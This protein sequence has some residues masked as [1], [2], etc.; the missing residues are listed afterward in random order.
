DAEVWGIDI[1]APMVRY[2]HMRARRLGVEVQFAQRLAEKT[3]FPDGYFD[4]VTSYIVHHE[5]PA[6]ITLQVIDEV[7]RITRSGGVYYPID[8]ISGGTQAP[9]RAIYGRWW[10]HRWNHEV[11]S[12]EYHALDFSAEIARRGFRHVKGTPPAL[13]NFG[14]RHFVREA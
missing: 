9:P 13:P 4:L 1:A 2:A 5:M 3:A 12:L 14:L 11:W 6:T 10:D 8:F 7:R